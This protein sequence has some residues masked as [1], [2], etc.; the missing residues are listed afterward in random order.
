MSKAR[1]GGRTTP[2]GTR[3]GGR[4][5]LRVM[6]RV[7]PWPRTRPYLNARRWDLA[8]VNA[9]LAFEDARRTRPYGLGA[10]PR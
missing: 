7:S 4:R 1:K 5:R 10:L 6:P 2:K 9:Q 8:A 3:P